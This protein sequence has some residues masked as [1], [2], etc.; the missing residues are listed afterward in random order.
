[1]D[2]V[3]V[4]ATMGLGILLGGV[5]GAIG[6]VM[7]GGQVAAHLRLA[8]LRASQD[9]LRDVLAE[10][11]AAVAREQDASAANLR[12]TSTRPPPPSNNAAHPSTPPTPACST[13]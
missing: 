6:G 5:I 1:M 11:E 8:P 10:Y 3:D 12:K 13:S 7:A 4:C 2:P 9:E